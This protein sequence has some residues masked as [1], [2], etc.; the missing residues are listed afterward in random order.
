MATSVPL[1]LM[2]DIVTVL[3]FPASLSEK[4]AEGVFNVTVSPDTTPDMLADALAD[5][6][7]SY[8]LSLAEIL[9]VTGFLVYVT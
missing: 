7:L 3:P 5:T 1:M 8:T 2:P 4:V 9:T 6:N